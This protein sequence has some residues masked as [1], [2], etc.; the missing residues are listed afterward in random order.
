MRGVGRGLKAIN[1]V[2]VFKEVAA[3]ISWVKQTFLSIS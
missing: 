1:H 2:T 3:L